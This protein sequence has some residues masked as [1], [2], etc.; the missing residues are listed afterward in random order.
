MPLNLIHG[1]PT[2]A[3]PGVVRRALRGRAGPRPGPGRADPRRRLRLRARALRGAARALGGVGA[4]LRGLFRRSPPPPARRPAPSSHRGPA[5]AGVARRG[6]SATRAARAAARARPTGPASPPPSCGLLDELQAAG[7]EPGGGRGGAATLEGSAYLERHRRPLRRLRRGCASSRGRVDAHGIA[8][9]GDRGRC[10][11]DPSFWGGRPVLLYG[12]DDLTAEQLELVERAGGAAEV[13]V[14]LPY[15]DGQRGAG[16]ARRACSAQLRERIGGDRGDATEADPAN[17]DSPLLFHLARGF[18]APAPRRAEPD[19]GLT[20]LRSAGERGEAEAIAAEVVAAA[21]R[22]RRP[23][24]DRDRPARPGAARRGDRR[25]RWRRTAIADGAGGRAAGRRDRA[26]A[27]P[28]SRC[29]R[30]SSAAGRAADLLRYLR[31]PV[32]LLARAGST[33]SSAR[34]GA[35]GSR[36]RRRRWRSGRARRASRRATCC[37]CARRRR[38]RRRRWRPRSGGWR[39]RWRRGRCAARATGR[40]LGPR[41][42]ARAAGGRSDRRRARR[43]GRARA[44]WRRGPRSWRRRSRRSTFR[45]WSGPGRGP[46]ADRQPLPAARRPLRPR[47]RRLAAGRRVPAPRPRRRPLPLRGAAR[48]R[49]GLDPRRDSEAEERY[50][51][52]V[53]LALPRRRLFLSYRDSDENGGAE[54]RSPLLDEVRALLAPAARRIARRTRSR[55]RS[56]AAATWPGSSTRSPRRPPRTSWRAPLAAHGPSAD[57]GGAAG[58]GRASTASWPP[59]SRAG[60]PP[61]AR[62]EAASRAPGPL[63]NPAVIESLAAVARLRRHHPGGVRPLLL[64][65][66]RRP[67][68]RPAAARPGARPAG[69]GRADARGRSTASTASAP[70]ATRCPAP[71]RSP[72]GSRAGASSS[73]RSSPSASSAPTRPSGRW[74]AGSSAC[75]SASSPRRPRARPAASSPGCWRPASASTRTASGRRWSSTAGA[76][77]ARSTASTARADGRAV[78]IDYKLSGAVTPREKFEEQAKL[79][80]PLYLLAVA[81]ALGRRAGRRPLPPAARRPRRGARAASSREEAAGDLAGYGLYDRDVVDAEELRASCWRTRGGAPARSSPACAAATSAATP[82]RAAACAATTSAPPSATFAP[83]CRRD[84]APQ[85]EEDEEVEER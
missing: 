75:W 60:S 30:P 69:P 22:R 26:S 73:P 85:Y 17:T 34:C 71:A 48:R 76:C 6:R 72:P 84:R 83:I 70:A 3:A 80:L 39:R 50:L 51:F 7:V 33:G 20:L 61:P 77:T 62:A 47:L 53:C 82:A 59:G 37:G 56:P 43:A 42:R 46:G 44:A 23:G 19:D 49:S 15:E 74:R 36:T 16:G 52:G 55:R 79:Q 31:G 54:A 9:D 2:P 35:A 12:L 5:P 45:V 78:V 29:S 13:T 64:P 21:R 67:R 38:A 81:R 1:P 4:D 66:V 14:S 63:T 10:A 58:G 8:R 41:R 25:R 65:L 24:R 27:A 11:R 28:W 18:G 32:G 57:A 40:A 68:A